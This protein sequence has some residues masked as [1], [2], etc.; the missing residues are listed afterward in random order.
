[1]DSQ[2]IMGV[3]EM[4]V[5]ECCGCFEQ[6]DITRN[7]YGPGL[8]QVHDQPGLPHVPRLACPSCQ[9]RLKTVDISQDEWSA[10]KRK[11]NVV[12]N[13]DPIEQIA[14]PNGRKP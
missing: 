1:M 3:G 9:G 10:L 8:T 14:F 11:W 4:R 2:E 12:K 7:R 13:Y 6:Y 5:L